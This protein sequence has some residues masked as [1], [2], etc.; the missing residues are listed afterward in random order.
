MKVKDVLEVTNN[1]VSIMK[2]LFPI[3]TIHFEKKEANMLSKD[4][5]NSKVRKIDVLDKR[6]RIWLEETKNNKE[7]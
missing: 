4:I 2:G 3:V 7:D 5:L 1:D 6:I